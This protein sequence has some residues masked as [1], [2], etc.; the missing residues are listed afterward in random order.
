M[1]EPSKRK[2]TNKLDDKGVVDVKAK[3]IVKKVKNKM[4]SPFISVQKEW[5][6]K[7]HFTIPEDLLKGITE[8]LDFKR[9][10]KIQ[11]VAIPMFLKKDDNGEYEDLIAQ[12]KNGSG[13]TGAFVIGSLLRVDPAIK[14]P[15]V[16]CFGHS[17]ELVNQ[18]SEVYKLATKYSDITV[19][20]LVDEVSKPTEHVLITTLG[21]LLSF[22][23]RNKIDFS[24]LRCVIF[25]EA[26][27][28]FEQ[29]RAE[30][31]LKNF[32]S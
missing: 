15:Q 26:D 17:R 6:N 8:G 5:S 29:N 25:D 23:G 11:A 14:K 13:K 12:S 22:S 3:Q 21:K 16:V 24:E 19:K 10:S 18:I 32:A 31:E 4:D 9:P 2:V 1:V 20:N 28:F 27:S 7:E 30:D